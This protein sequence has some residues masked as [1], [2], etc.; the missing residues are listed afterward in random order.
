M[1]IALLKPLKEDPNGSERSISLFEDRLS[2]KAEVVEDNLRTD[3]SKTYVSKIEAVRWALQPTD[4]TFREDTSF[5][6]SSAALYRKAL[7]PIWIE[8]VTPRESY[9]SPEQEWEG[10][11]TLVGEGIFTARLLDLTTGDDVEEEEADFSI[12]S[13]SDDNK[14]LL[15]VGGIFRW[16]IGF[17][18]TIDGAKR[19]A[20]IIVFRRI[21][22][23]TTRDFEQ[24]ALEAEDLLKIEWKDEDEADG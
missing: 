18:R 6:E 21:P 8:P 19:H 13:L 16:A 7:R 10:Y 15:R 11:V 1:A 24:A 3:L 20:S 12:A 22:A 23:W 5:F 2:T 17:Q 9:F 14:T 4:Q